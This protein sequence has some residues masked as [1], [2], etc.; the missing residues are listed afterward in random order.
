MQL[1]TDNGVFIIDH[2]SMVLGSD[3]IIIKARYLKFIPHHTETPSEPYPLE[4]SLNGPQWDD[5]PAG[6][7]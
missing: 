4:N 7:V 1:Y 2:Y 6:G 5:I 3:E